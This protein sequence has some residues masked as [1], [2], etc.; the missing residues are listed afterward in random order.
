[1]QDNHTTFSVCSQQ[2]YKICTHTLFFL[3]INQ[4]YMLKDSNLVLDMLDDTSSM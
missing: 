2:K 4:E 3:I 1:M